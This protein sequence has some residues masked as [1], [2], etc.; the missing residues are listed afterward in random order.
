[1]FN[2][3]MKRNQLRMIKEKSTKILKMPETLESPLTKSRAFI[4]ALVEE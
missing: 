4:F 3:D 2:R 1:M